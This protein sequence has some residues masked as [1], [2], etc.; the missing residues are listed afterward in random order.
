MLMG[1]GLVAVPRHF[2]R[3]ASPAEQLRTLYCA[4]VNMDES[5]LSTQFELQDVIGEARIEILSRSS[6]IGDTKLER[7]FSILQHTLEEC[8]QLHCELTNGAMASRE[9]S[10]GTTVRTSTIGPDSTRI[11]CLAQIHHALKQAGLEARRSACR[12]DDMAQRCLLLED[13]EERMF[14]SAVE[15]ATSWQDAECPCARMLCRIPAVRSCWHNL[16]MLWLR[17][18]RPR[19]CRIF[20]GLC[21]CLSGIIVL[22]QLTMFSESW[23]L[24]ILALLFHRN[25]GFGLTQVLCILPLTYMVC[26]AYWSVFRLKITGWYGLYS[27]HNTDTGSLL[28]CA[29]LLARLA[30]P[31]SYHFLLLVRVKGTAFQVMMG[32]MNVVPVLGRSFNEIFPCLVGFLCLCN[33]LNVYSRCVQ[34]CGLDSLE[35]ELAPSPNS[36]PPDDV[37]AE[38]RRLIDRERRRRV[39]ERSLLEMEEQHTLRGTI[40]LRVQIA[41]LIEDGTLP[42]DW[43]AHSQ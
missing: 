22:G 6:T 9:G 39:E 25:H 31:L 33:L 1:Y 17:P 12:W 16:L 14:P 32:Q 36:L 7:A 38:G 20:G 19:A 37:L 21:G 42:R 5:R 29:S 13:L 4:A 10:Q 23:S 30:A 18:L 43:N 41:R 8:E 11:E 2:W 24:S 34:F 26:T 35:F 27:N 3:L 40:P 28:W 15:L